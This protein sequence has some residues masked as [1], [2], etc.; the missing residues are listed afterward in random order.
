MISILFDKNK[1]FITMNLDVD[2]LIGFLTKNADTI[3]KEEVGEQ[4]SSPAP[5]PSTGGGGSVP[6]WEDSYPLKRGK[7]N[8]LTKSGEKWNTGLTRGAANQIW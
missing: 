7:A 8:P 5:A 3:S 1:I 6:K 2:F 4:D